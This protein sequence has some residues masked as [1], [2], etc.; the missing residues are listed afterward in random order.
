[1]GSKMRYKKPK[2]KYKLFPTYIKDMCKPNQWEKWG[3]GG[4]CICGKANGLSNTW[5]G[6]LCSNCEEMAINCQQVWY[7]RL[8]K[9]MLR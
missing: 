6:Y 7:V 1:M 2:V 5:E 4:Y 9:W 8:L 3:G